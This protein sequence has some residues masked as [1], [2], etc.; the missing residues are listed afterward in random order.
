MN[1]GKGLKILQEEWE[2]VHPIL[3]A[4]GESNL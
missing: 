1:H 3:A 4:F 2:A